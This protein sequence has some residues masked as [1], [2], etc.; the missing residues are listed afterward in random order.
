MQDRRVQI[1]LG[2]ALAL[3]GLA[4]AALAEPSA[5][6]HQVLEHDFDPVLPGFTNP[7]ASCANNGCANPCAENQPAGGGYVTCVCPGGSG[8]D[9]GCNLKYKLT[10]LGGGKY[11][12]AIDCMLLTCTAHGGATDCKVKS[13]T[14]HP[15]GGLTHYKHYCRCQVPPPQ[16]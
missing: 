4:N 16:P 6:C 7:Q 15:P 11:N 9:Q 2:I 14:T 1:V 10:A 13:E 5:A 3:F 12:I 8:D